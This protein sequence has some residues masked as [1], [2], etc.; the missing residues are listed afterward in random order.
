[1]L[2]FCCMRL[3][4]CD[5]FAA[6][7]KLMKITGPLTVKTSGT[8]FGAWMTDP[9]ASSKNNRVSCVLLIVL[10]KPFIYITV[11]RRQHGSLAL[12]HTHLSKLLLSLAFHFLIKPTLTSA[13][14]CPTCYRVKADVT[15]GSLSK[16]DISR[17]WKKKIYSKKK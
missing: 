10:R 15:Y 3:Q 5:A 11:A 7:G 12:C 4:L 1:M 16:V 14:C 6:C 2:G 17:W 9:Q 8:R 13:G